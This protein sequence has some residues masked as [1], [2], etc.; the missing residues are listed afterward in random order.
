MKRTTITVYLGLALFGALVL[1]NLL[2][3]ARSTVRVVNLG[4]A[5][6]PG[7]VITVDDHRLEFR[8]LEGGARRFAL[9]PESGDA[10]LQVRLGAGSDTPPA[11]Q[12]YVQGDMFHVEVTLSGSSVHCRTDLPLLSDLLVF[13]LF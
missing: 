12:A 1:P 8:E 13:K 2:W 4:D 3:L 7:V 10:T 11:C 6:V 5:P 9:L